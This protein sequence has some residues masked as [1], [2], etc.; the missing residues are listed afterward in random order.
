MTA[1][2][3]RWRLIPKIL[4]ILAGIPLA[5]SLIATPSA[6]AQTF[7]LLHEFGQPGDGAEPTSGVIVDPAGNV[8]GATPSGGSFNYG[9]VFSL[10]AAGNESVLHNFLGGEG[11]SPAGGLFRDGAGNIYGTTAGGGTPE[12]GGCAHGCGTVFKRD[13]AGIQTEL[14][15]FTGKTDGGAPDAALIRDAAGNFYG[16]GSIGGAQFCYGVFGCGV[17][18]KL[19]P[20][21][22]E[23]VL[24]SFT[25]GTDGKFPHGL[26]ADA[27]GNLYGATYD[28]GTYG[29]GGVY[30]VDQ[31]GTLTVLHSFTGGADSDNPT[32]LLVRDQAGNLYGTTNS[33]LF[34]ASGFGIVYKLE[35]SGKLTVLHSFTEA[36]DGE[37]PSSLVR[38]AAG[39]LYGVTLGGGTGSGCYYGSCGTVFKLDTS[40]N[41]TVLHNFTG[42]DGQLPIGLSMDKAGNLYGTTLGGGKGSQCAYYKGCGVVFKL[43]L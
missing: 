15:A 10:D 16:T 38:D 11:L 22:Q 35:P 24:Y 32:G 40:G 27:E 13:A 42:S 17:I 36:A 19:D 33:G 25:D 2:A 20:A 3:Q 43:T 8:Y 5:I 7:T 37:Y 21:N 18:F 31:A 4:A 41:K 39:N 29:K 34:N 14:Y 1:N 9:I 26:V 12:N 23:S 30:E 6:Q 28:G